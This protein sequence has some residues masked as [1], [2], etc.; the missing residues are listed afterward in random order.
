M[1]RSESIVWANAGAAHEIMSQTYD[2][3]TFMLDKWYPADA[4]SPC[5]F[6]SKCAAVQ[7]RSVFTSLNPLQVMCSHHPDVITHSIS[8]SATCA[9]DGKTLIE[10]S[11]SSN[12]H[13]ACVTNSC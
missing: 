9:Y 3:W 11:K 7:C 8:L 1:S 10:H 12:V 6:S 13:V 4:K 2:L 5:A